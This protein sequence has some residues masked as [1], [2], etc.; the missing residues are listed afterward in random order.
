MKAWTIRYKQ[1]YNRKLSELTVTAVVKMWAVR[2]HCGSSMFY[3]FP[4]AICKV[5]VNGHNHCQDEQVKKY[6]VGLE[7]DLND[8]CMVTGWIGGAGS[9]GMLEM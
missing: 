3:W 5:P 6:L 4:Q 9:L 1:I 7:V 2:C 8:P